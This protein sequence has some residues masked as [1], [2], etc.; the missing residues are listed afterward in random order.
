MLTLFTTAKAFEGHSG[1]IQRNALHSWKLLHPDV[2]VILF[3]DDAGA[4]EVC[5]E[6]ELRFEPHVERHESG[7]K[8]ANHIFDRAQQI[9][10]HDMLCYSN[11]DIVLGPDFCEAVKKLRKLKQEYLMVGRR[12]DTDVNE[13]IDFSSPAWP[14]VIREKALH[15]NRPSDDWYLDYFV[16]RRG[17][18]LHRVPELVIGRIYWDNWLVWFAGQNGAVLVDGTSAFVAIHQNHDYGYHKNGKAGIWNDELAQRNLELAGGSAHLYSIR[19]VNYQL[20]TDGVRAKPKLEQ[21]MKYAKS[22]WRNRVWHPFLNWSRPLR[23]AI[24]MRARPGSERKRDEQA[25]ADKLT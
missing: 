9:A 1:I 12:W 17:L 22:D 7:M 19:Q 11:C 20:A 14:S 5:A 21:W 15:D 24:G 6:L 3:G 18:F 25:G 10:R 23:H 13:A 4:A 16:F 2:E 8:Y